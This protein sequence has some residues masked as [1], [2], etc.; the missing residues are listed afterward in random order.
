[1]VNATKFLSTVPFLHR[2]EMLEDLHLLAFISITL[3]TLLWY[4][5]RFENH[6]TVMDVLLRE[7]RRRRELR[8]FQQLHQ[9]SSETDSSETDDPMT[10]QT[11]GRLNPIQSVERKQRQSKLDDVSA[12]ASMTTCP[13]GTPAR[14]RP[15]FAG[16]NPEQSVERRR[17]IRQHTMDI[18]PKEQSALHGIAL[19]CL[20]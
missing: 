15:S 1:M 6:Q 2:F 17:R 13:I 8:L 18:E 12:L 16:L 10:T 9:E 11:F 14:S 4:A 19:I 3:L 5:S 20:M 7:R